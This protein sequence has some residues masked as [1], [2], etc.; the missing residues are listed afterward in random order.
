MERVCSECV[1]CTVANCKYWDDGNYCT[2]DQIL[3]TAPM[4]A[5][6][7]ADKHGMGAE[8]LKATPIREGEESLCYTFEPRSRV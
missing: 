1:R 6:P 8:Q 3:I 7:A 5:L 2:A 4:S